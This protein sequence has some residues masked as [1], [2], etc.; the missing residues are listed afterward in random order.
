M[1]MS[2]P[3]GL[4]AVWRSLKDS[5]EGS[6]ESYAKNQPAESQRPRR[7]RYGVP[8]LIPWCPQINPGYLMMAV[9]YV[10]LNP[11]RAKLCRAPWRWRWSSAAAHVEDRS[12]GLV[13]VSPMM[14]R[15]DDWRAY[16]ASGLSSEEANLLR[17]HERTGRPLGSLAFLKRLERKLGRVL[18]KKPASRKPKDKK[19]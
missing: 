16:L 10:E 14:G 5:R 3:D 1:S 4:W 2:E 7:N 19:K 9:R 11:V 18:R 8:R 13:A 17:E 12:D 6:A 15:V